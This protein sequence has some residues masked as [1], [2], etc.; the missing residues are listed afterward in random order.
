MKKVNLKNRFSQRKTKFYF[1]IGIYIL[2]GCMV[3]NLIVNSTIKLYLN[4]SKPV[5]AYL[6]L[7]GSITREFYIAKIAK[8]NPEI[9][10]IISKGSD[11][12]CIFLIFERKKSPMNNV[13]LEKCANSTFGNFFFSIPMLK[14][15]G[16]KKVTVIT[17]DT[18]LP[19][20]KL[21]AEIFLY[22]QG[23]AL[24]MKTVKEYK[25]I[26]ANY[27][28]TI[29]TTLDVTRSILWVFVG[30]FINPPCNNVI[31]LSEIDLNWWHKKGFDCEHQVGSNL[32]RIK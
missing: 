25:G 3:L 6:V 18:H 32:N 31:K 15:W 16:V 4:S 12:P 26:P 29:K 14:K 23:I 20:A 5:D 7:G 28:N 11:D 9:P 27:E 22:S 24:D 1:Q 10:I 21:V 17:S 30:Q 2:L 13:W 19:R 8:D